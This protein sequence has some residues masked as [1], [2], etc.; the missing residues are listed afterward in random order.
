MPGRD[1]TV[2]SMVWTLALSL[3]REPRTRAEGRGQQ[4]S[5]SSRGDLR[6]K[7]DYDEHSDGNYDED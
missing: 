7:N 4:G 5:L 3:L 2:A 1:L 6:G